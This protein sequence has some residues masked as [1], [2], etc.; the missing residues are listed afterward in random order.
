MFVME[1]DINDLGIWIKEGG[2]SATAA[3][4]FQQLF[5]GTIGCDLVD[6]P[7][8]FSVEEALRIRMWERV[9]AEEITKGEFAL[10]RHRRLDR[11]RA[12]H[13]C[14]RGG[15]ETIAKGLMAVADESRSEP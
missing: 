5:D 8:F 9:G 13:I 2:E 12:S 14:P 15:S 7:H 6:R 3:A 1:I 11:C 4:H 10:V